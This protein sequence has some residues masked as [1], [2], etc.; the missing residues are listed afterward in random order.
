MDTTLINKAILDNEANPFNMPDGDTY[1]N[2]DYHLAIMEGT[3]DL[4]M[5]RCIVWSRQSE[6]DATPEELYAICPDYI[7]GRKMCY[8][9]GKNRIT[10]D[11]LYIP[12]PDHKIPMVHGGV[13][14][15]DNLVIVPLKYNIWKRDI[16]KEDWADFKAWM[17]NHLD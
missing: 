3:M 6:Y 7:N 17:D 14:T 1:L 12:S 11:P 15:I 9:M 13:K 4:K 8:G 2:G 16:L 5:L 10:N